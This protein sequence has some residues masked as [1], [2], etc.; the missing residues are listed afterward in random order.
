MKYKIKSSTEVGFQYVK[1]HF[2]KIDIV[3]WVV[4]E[5][6]S[7]FSKEDALFFIQLHPNKGLALE[8]V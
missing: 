1:R 4:P 5:I 8:E 6:A 2:N 7:I 3:A